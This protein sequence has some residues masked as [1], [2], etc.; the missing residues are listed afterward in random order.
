MR[1]DRKHHGKSRRNFVNPCRNPTTIYSGKTQEE[2]RE[3][4][5]LGAIMKKNLEEI[6][7]KIWRTLLKNF[8]RNQSEFT[9][10]SGFWRKNSGKNFPNLG[11]NAGINQEK[12]P[13]GI[14]KRKTRKMAW[15]NTE[16]ILWDI[17]EA[18]AAL[19]GKEPLT[20]V[21][22]LGTDPWP[23]AYEPNMWPIAPRALALMDWV[24]VKNCPKIPA[25]AQEDRYPRSRRSSPTLL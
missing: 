7:E 24:I 5:T 13:G 8:W 19:R 11:K 14:Q 20:K 22:W 6:V 10:P 1:K 12:S 3:K 9:N 21:P 25:T 16:G 18:K 23:S 4:R 17:L 15:K 2:H